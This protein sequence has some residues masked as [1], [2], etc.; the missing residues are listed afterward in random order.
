MLPDNWNKM[1]P[2]EKRAYRLNVW[3]TTEG[4]PFAT[5]EAAKLYTERGQRYIDILNL[6]QPDRVPVS[7][8]VGDYIANYTGVPKGD[9]FYDYPKAIEATAKFCREFDLEYSVVGNFLPG[10]VYDI[11]GYQLYK[12][13]GGALPKTHTFQFVEGEYMRA[14]EYD[15]LIRDPEDWALHKYMPRVQKN[16][17]G[18]AAFPTFFGTT[19]M[20]FVP[21]TMVNFAVPPIK[22]TLETMI[23]AGQATLEW[24]GA[25]AQLGAV[26]M[27]ELGLPATLGGFSKAPFDFLGDSL[28]GT[29]GIM[30]DLF[31]RPEKVLAAV[32]ALT[33]MAIRMGI[34]AA[35]AGNNP[36]IF[37][38]LHK[39]ADGFM[40]TPDFKKFYWPTLKAVIEGLIEDGC[41]PC[42]FV[43]GGYNQRLDA[44]AE[45]PVESGKTMWM[46]DQTNM[47]EAK[48]K[49]GP[50]AAI[51]GNVP[52]SMLKAGTPQQVDDY[53]KKLVD[54]CAPGGGFFLSPGAVLDD[55]TPEN[56]RAYL[57]AGKKHGVY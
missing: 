24:L 31:R 34:G 42:M 22:E 15:E 27:G 3:L 13:P 51:G 50:W 32:E 12:W 9:F 55:S 17:P 37:I 57:A 20:P 41:V 8:S 10:K 40:S 16:T 56:L 39:G 29:R 14:D 44:L 47:A 23:A 11:V 46:F 49:I 1:T 33:P 21:F 2:E 5:A 36:F 35:N 48:K 38:P 7:V 52:V 45:N 26:T 18:L 25:N 53:V 6:K 28:R 4:K 43:E 19:E 30:M 54:D